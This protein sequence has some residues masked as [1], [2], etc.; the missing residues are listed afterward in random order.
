MRPPSRHKTPN[1]ALGLDNSEDDT[2]NKRQLGN[3]RPNTSKVGRNVNLPLS[4]E[5]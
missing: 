3:K 5:N 2:N 1:K 4:P